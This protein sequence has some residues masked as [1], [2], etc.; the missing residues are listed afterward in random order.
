MYIKLLYILK[1]DLI[2]FYCRG[3]NFIGLEIK[4]LSLTVYFDFVL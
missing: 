3:V 2:F 4:E 1:Y